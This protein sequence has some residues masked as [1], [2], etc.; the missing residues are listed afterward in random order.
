MA[1]IGRHAVVLSTSGR[2]VDVSPF[3]PDYKPMTVEIVDAAV[4]YECPYSHVEAIL[5]IR[6]ALS[7]P[8]MEHNLIPPFMMREAGVTVS[9]TP[10]IQVSQ[11]SVEDHSIFFPET[12]FR[13][14]LSLE[15]VFSYFPTSKP[16]QDDLE[17]SDNIYMLTPT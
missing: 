12:G 10:K 6:N 8:S 11:P 14:P 3:T 2:K 17:H 7:F 9:T 5:V 4:K 13:I 16:M 1:V 15:G